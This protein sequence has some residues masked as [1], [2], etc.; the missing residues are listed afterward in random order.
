MKCTACARKKGLLD[1]QTNLKAL[2]ASDA[3]DIIHHPFSPHCPTRIAGSAPPHNPSTSPKIV[4]I[5]ES[6]MND[7]Q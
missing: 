1:P 6:M 3:A 4:I 7:S 5:D 2:F